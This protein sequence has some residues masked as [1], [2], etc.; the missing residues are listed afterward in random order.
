MRVLVVSQDTQVRARSGAALRARPEL[1]VVEAHSA[2][3]AHRTIAEGGIDVVVMDGDM[4]PEGG[5]SVMYEI[6]AGAELREEEAPPFIVL[7]EREVDRWLGKWAGV[8]EA[9]LKPVNPFVLAERVAELGGS[10]GGEPETAGV[11]AGE[12]MAMDE[13]PELHDEDAPPPST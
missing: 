11:T 12:Q 4:R 6:R 10:A 2:A 1:E 5:Y 8:A 3:E 7:M 13:P 9:Y